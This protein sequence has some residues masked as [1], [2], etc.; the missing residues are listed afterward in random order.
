MANDDKAFVDPGNRSIIRPMAR[1]AICRAW[2]TTDENDRSPKCPCGGDLE[3]VDMEAYV[4]AVEPYVP[5]DP[6]KK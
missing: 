3:L 5:F 2:W 4:K 6:A 1:C